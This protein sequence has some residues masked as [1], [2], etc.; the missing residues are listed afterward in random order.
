MN[1]M[2]LTSVLFFLLMN[3]IAQNVGI[4]NTDPKAA[5]DLNGGFRLRSE[6]TTITSSSGLIPVLVKA[7]QEQQQRIEELEKQVKKMKK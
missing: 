1:K 2:L 6:N 3:A 5:L 7:I 4:N